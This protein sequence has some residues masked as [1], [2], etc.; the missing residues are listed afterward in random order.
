MTP[1]A[2]AAYEA[3]LASDGYVSNLTRVWCWR[4]DVQASFQALRA[5]LVAGSSLSA[6]EVAV[7]NASAA[8]AR[9][10]SYCSLAWGSRLAGLSD[11]ATAA[12][13]LRGLDTGLSGLPE[14]EVALARWARQVVVDPNA[15]T[16]ADAES[17]RAAGFGDQEIFD[18]TVLVALRLAFSSVNDALGA[19]PD[20]QL[21]EQAPPLVREAVT[22]GRP[23]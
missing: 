12:G 14:R 21:A 15:T 8:A 2:A 17:L 13:V 16:P 11:E 23:S 9:G 5:E 10:D 22:Y 19:R 1:P 3:D 20:P 7:I 6:R 18:A 4:P